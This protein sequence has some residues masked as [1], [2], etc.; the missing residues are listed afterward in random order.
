MN[1]RFM[2]ISLAVICTFIGWI[3]GIETA[4]HLV[5][6]AFESPEV[7]RVFVDGMKR[8][9]YGEAAAV[10]GILIPTK[11]EG[12]DIETATYRWSDKMPSIDLTGKGFGGVYH[13]KFQYVGGKMTILAPI[14]VVPYRARQLDRNLD[15]EWRTFALPPR[16]SGVQK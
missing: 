1:S 10:N 9:C 13:E 15:D 3:A 5:K 2:A 4:K 14:T 12:Y 8:A 11:T 16:W 7:K 6:E